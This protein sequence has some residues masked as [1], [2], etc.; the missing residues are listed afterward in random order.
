MSNKVV[1]RRAKRSFVW[2]FMDKTTIDPNNNTVKCKIC[3]QL[4]PYDYC[5]TSTLIY[6]LSHE[7]RIYRHNYKNRNAKKKIRLM[8]LVSESES[9]FEEESSCDTNKG[10]L[11]SRK[12]ELINE[13]L[14]NFL[15][16]NN[17][18]IS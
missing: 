5:S 18:P 8:P 9:E 13:K 2:E 11:A 10:S 1:K 16:N 17:Q 15:I 12:V 14:L 7:H 4:V 6:H 3:R